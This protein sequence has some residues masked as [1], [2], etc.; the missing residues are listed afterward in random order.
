MMFIGIVFFILGL[1]IGVLVTSNSI[2]RHAG[3]GYFKIEPVDEDEGTYKVNV[4]INDQKLLEHD[5]VILMRDPS[6][7]K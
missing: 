3:Y 6:S 2:R 1:L 5:R 7:Q 4:C